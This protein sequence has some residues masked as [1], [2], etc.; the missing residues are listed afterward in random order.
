MKLI[1]I[2]VLTIMLLLG[3]I[4]LTYAQQAQPAG[5]W[6]TN[7]GMMSLS[8]SGNIVEGRYEQNNGKFKGKLSGSILGGYWYQANSEMKCDSPK[9]GTYYWGRLKFAVKGDNLT[10][11]WGYCEEPMKNSDFS[12]QRSR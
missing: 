2:S 9:Y 10:G 3:L 7:W 5:K 12:G 11:I 4:A 8:K 1:R 6:Q